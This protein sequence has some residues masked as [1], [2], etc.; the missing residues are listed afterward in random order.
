MDIDTICRAAVAL[1]ASDIHL[2]ANLPPLV[3]VNGDI[4]PIPRRHEC[5]RSS[6]A[7]WPGT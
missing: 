2:K 4:L 5:P 6:W 1:G 3:R 7:R